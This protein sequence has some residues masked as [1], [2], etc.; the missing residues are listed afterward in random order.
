MLN[1]LSEEQASRTRNHVLIVGVVSTLMVWT[2]LY[3]PI[4]LPK[5]FMLSCLSAWILGTIA[6]NLINSKFKHL[7]LGV[8]A[9]ISFIVGIFLAAILTDVPYTAFF[10]AS[11]RND[12]AISYFFLAVLCLAGMMSFTAENLNRLRITLPALGMV[13]AI[14][15]LLQAS[16]HDPFK[17]VLL[18]GPIVG[19]VGNPDF[20]SATLGVCAVATAWLVLTEERIWIRSTAG[21]LAILEIYVAKRSGSVQGLL[22]FAAGLVILLLTKL[23]QKNRRLGLIGIAAAAAA[24]VPAIAGFMN[25][26]P[27]A[28]LLFRSSMKNRLDYWHA[29]I[30]MFKVHPIF[31]VGFDRFGENYGLYAPKIQVVHGQITNNAHNVFL[32][33]LA[34]GGLVVILPYLFLLG[35][36][37]YSALKAIRVSTGRRQMDIVGLFSIWFSLFLISIL[38]IDNIGVTVWFWISGG[39]LYAISRVPMEQAKS[40]E[41]KLRK[42]GKGRQASLSNNVNYTAPIV[43]LVLTLLV[44]ILMVPAWRASAAIADLQSNRSRLSPSNYLQKLNQVADS[45]PKNPQTLFYLSDL[46]MRIQKP[47]LALKFAQE[48]IAM[49]PK[50][51]SGRQIAAIALESE[52]KYGLAIPF[53]IEL[54]K[55]DPWNTANM[56]VLV[57]DYV[58]IKDEIKAKT[59]AARI[60][61]L[62]PNSADAISAAA[63]VKG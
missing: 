40:A 59:M 38:S 39:V 63:L 51:N 28:G 15:G 32:Q 4:N 58:Q 29:A 23:W 26:G 55:L 52:K 41:P 22:A 47:D 56:L 1:H 48:V 33:L 8:W 3:D 54:L 30:A 61:Q 7:P 11:Q 62:Y 49:D 9:V 5:M 24:A 31:G 12:G 20:M 13:L 37:L 19:T 46:G 16:G 43:S 6:V 44:V 34:T 60:A 53:R 17:W 21:I 27:L 45:W 18:Y 57:Q 25:K 14:H 36:I 50:T 10:G 35:V 2:S 42:S